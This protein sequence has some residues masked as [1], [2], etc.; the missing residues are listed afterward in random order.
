[1]GS[2]Q[3]RDADMDRL[4]RAVLKPAS[5][6]GAGAC[7]D[8]G[9][10]A[11]FVEGS[12][13]ANEQSALD[14]HMVECGRCQ[15]TLAIL[16]HELPAQEAEPVAPAETGWFTWVTRPRLRWLVP[17]SAAATVAAVFFATRPLIAPEGEVPGSEV[18]RMTQ[19]PAPSAEVPEA[20]LDALHEKPVVATGK[21]ELAGVP[22][23]ERTAKSLTVQPPA[24]SGAAGVRADVQMPGEERARDKRP[25]EPA[26]E[27][28]AARAASEEKRAQMTAPA[29]VVLAPA[30][31]AAPVAGA[32]PPPAAGQAAVAQ[33]AANVPAQEDAV[34]K[35]TAA[36]KD[37]AAR[38]AGGTPAKLVRSPGT[39]AV[40]VREPGGAVLWRVG[41]SGWV[42][43]SIDGG[44]SWQPQ[45][46][47]VTADLLAGSAPSPT[48]CWVVGMSGTVLLTTDGQRWQRRAFPDR[49]DLIAV[50]ATNDRAAV[51]MARDGRRFET[52]DGGLTWSLK[53]P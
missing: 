37:R 35:E 51:V 8:P 45:P 13:T 16:S 12:L 52:S 4:L 40:T 6:T 36:E 3:K 32:P 30:P 18:V 10:L 17:I 25:A 34:R 23:R 9:V 20:G 43:R 49:V 26:A 31:P 19:A 44:V 39:S 53:Q 27:M 42:S 15:E 14:A 50:A 1:V 46:S 22:E 48:V 2:D 5:Q 28:M 47:G 21:S 29:P 24:A 7:P 38:V 41:A 11:A 33:Q